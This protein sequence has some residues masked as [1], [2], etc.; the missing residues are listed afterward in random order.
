MLAPE[1][2]HTA[3]VVGASLGTFVSAFVL[4]ASSV[5]AFVGA[6]VQ[7]PS[8][9]RPLE[10]ISL[11]GPRLVMRRV[12]ARAALILNYGVRSL[13]TTAGTRASIDGVQR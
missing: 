5:G 2:R 1:R 10:T 4:E 7:T 13:G 8:V 6:L 9:S 11:L 12:V 3:V